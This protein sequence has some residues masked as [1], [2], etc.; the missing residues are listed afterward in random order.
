MYD[1]SMRVL[2]V[3]ELLQSREH[4]TGAE[5]ARRLEVSPRTVQRY[6]ARLQDLGLPVEGRRGVGGAYRLKPGFRL[7]PLMFSGEEALSLALGLLAL[8]HLGL[9]ALAPAAEGAAAKLRRT[10]PQEL[11]DEIGALEAAVQLGVSPWVV[12]TDAALLAALLRA[13]R[14]SVSVRFA[15]R[16]R[17]GEPSRREVDVYRA[18]QFGGRWYAVG[19]CHTRRALRCFR[20]DRMSD[21]TLLDTSFTPPDD[22]DALAYL[23]KTL[24]ATPQSW[25]I[26]VWLDTPPE[27]LC[28][29]LSDWG[30]ELAAEAGGTRLKAQREELEPFAAALLGLGCEVQIDE[31]PQL[32]DAFAA[33]ARRSARFARIG[34]P[35]SAASHPQVQGVS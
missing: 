9:S 17:L 28:G 34:T 35:P 26:N 31:P 12:P 30:T 15:Y 25:T 3:L 6:V 5:L 10:L 14:R 23:Q 33:L 8:R 19:R 7:P 4:V 1:P 29:R 2:T 18:A 24:P 13:V 20:L 11:R 16:S 21:L 27:A 32:R 22:F